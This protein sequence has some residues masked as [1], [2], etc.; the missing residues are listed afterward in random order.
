M[1]ER[2]DGIIRRIEDEKTSQEERE[3]TRDAMARIEGVGEEKVRYF[4]SSHH[5]VS[6]LSDLAV[7]SSRLQ[8]PKPH[9][10]MKGNTNIAYPLA[11]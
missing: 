3:R 9:E 4:P 6:C 5:V 8:P 11:P 1:L 2:V 10:G 7:N